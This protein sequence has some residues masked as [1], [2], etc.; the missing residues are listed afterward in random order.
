M[1]WRVDPE[2]SKIEF[3]VQHLRVT[4]VRGRFE[5]FEGTLEMN[6]EEPEASSVAG[7]VDVASIKT[8]ISMRDSNLRGRGRFDAGRFP[9][10]SFRS[11][12]IED[13]KGVHFQVYGDLTIKDITRPVMFDVFNK[14]ELPAKD[15]K[16][17]WAFGASILVNRKDFDIKWNAFFE[18]GNVFVRD[19]VKGELVMLFVQE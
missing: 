2:G 16:R 4:T 5:S 11:T 13:F 7:T 15:G 10:M 12:R 14:G 6:E 9:R 19:E 3:L 8:G 1:A 17:R 18:A